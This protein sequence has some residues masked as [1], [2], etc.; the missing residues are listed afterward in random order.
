LLVGD[1]VGETLTEFTS[2]ADLDGDRVRFGVAVTDA[3]SA[4]KER[5]LEQDTVGSFVTVA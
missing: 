5:D 2:D 4:E 1:D 3:G